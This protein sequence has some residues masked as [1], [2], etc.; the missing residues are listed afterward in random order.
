[1]TEIVAQP[2][3]NQVSVVIPVYNGAAHIAKAVESA[4][5]Q[6]YAPLE[7]IVVDDGSDDGT[8]SVLRV[9]QKPDPS[10][11]F[12]RLIPGARLHEIAGFRRAE[13]N[14]SHFLTRMIIGCRASLTPS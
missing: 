13:G 1:M 5:A 9:L 6:E 2:K 12:A 14:G 4:W 7:V 10:A 3:L 11:V 8:D